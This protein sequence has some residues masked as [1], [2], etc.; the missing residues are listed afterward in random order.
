MESEFPKGDPE[1]PLFD[2]EVMEKFR[3]LVPLHEVHKQ[4]I[5]ECIMQLENIC[6]SELIE[7]LHSAKEIVQ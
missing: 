7:V 1:N 3:D 5:L 4:R 6:V 2:H